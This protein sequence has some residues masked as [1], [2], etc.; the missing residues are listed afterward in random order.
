LAEVQGSFTFS[1]KQMPHAST[2]IQNALLEFEGEMPLLS[3]VRRSRGCL[4]FSDLDGV[5]G[6]NHVLRNLN[7]S[8]KLNKHDVVAGIFSIWEVKRDRVA[9]KSKY[10]FCL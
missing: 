3:G 8:W 5:I 9:N 10:Q 4:H 7:A 6:A 2:Y 1:P